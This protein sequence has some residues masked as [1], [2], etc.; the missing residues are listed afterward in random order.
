MCVHGVDCV[1]IETHTR[2]KR[3]GGADRFIHQ[4]IRA[5]GRELAAAKNARQTER[6]EQEKKNDGNI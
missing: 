6:E 4:V 2:R 5:D 3:E 1:C